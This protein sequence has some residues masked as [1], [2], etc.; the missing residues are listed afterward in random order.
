MSA[1]KWVYTNEKH[2]WI[3][4]LTSELLRGILGELKPCKTNRSS[5]VHFPEENLLQ[6]KTEW[7]RGVSLVKQGADPNICNLSDDSK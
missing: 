1:G 5:T 7:Q 4:R 3:G 2:Q 6:W